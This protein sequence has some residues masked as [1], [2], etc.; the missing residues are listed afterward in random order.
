VTTVYKGL[1]N[2]IYRLFVI[3]LVLDYGTFV[4]PFLTLYLSFH[5]HIDEDRIGVY[6]M[7]INVGTI[8]GSVMGGSLSDRYGRKYVIIFSLILSAACY[9]MVPWAQSSTPAI[10]LISLSMAVFAMADPAF[11]A[12]VGDLT[13]GPQREAAF[14]LLYLGANAGLSAGALTASYLFAKDVRLLFWGEGAITLIAGVGLLLTLKTTP[15]VGCSEPKEG[16][17]APVTRS[18]HDWS[19]LLL[20]SPSIMIF[21]ALYAAH[22]IIYSQVNFSLPLFLTE[23]YPETGVGYYGRMIAINTAAVILL[24]PI[25]NSLTQ[26]RSALGCVAFGI[27][28]Y[29]VGFGLYALTSNIV[30]I[31]SSVFIW[32]IGEI[33]TVT[34]AKVFVAEMTTP[35][36]R[37][38]TN[39]LID[40]SYEIGY[41]VGPFM[42]G[43]VI[44]TFGVIYVWPIIA[45]VALSSAGGLW[46][47]YRKLRST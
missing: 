33:L 20:E 13:E 17:H 26:K 34:H 42:F 14:S 32:T 46:L 29:S 4:L 44:A 3:K 38:R 41:S 19:K 47:L 2:A 39:T 23:A 6:L 40:V 5:Y 43:K 22:P 9:M 11:N 27:G 25:I 24:S 1:P 12:L 10:A 31:F 45:G 15:R 37:G 36:T 18:Q 28:L 7:I 30:W 35:M 16:L 21:A 8:L